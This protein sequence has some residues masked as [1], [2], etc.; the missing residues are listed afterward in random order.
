MYNKFRQPNSL[1]IE[2]LSS[3]RLYKGPQDRYGT[4]PIT[5]AI[6]KPSGNVNL[7]NVSMDSNDYETLSI[8]N[9]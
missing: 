7:K 6:A 4:T 8:V 3:L 1:H 2:A 5:N 9:T